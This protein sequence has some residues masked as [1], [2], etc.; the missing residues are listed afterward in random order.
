MKPRSPVLEAL[1]RRYERSQAGRT[2]EASRDVLALVAGVLGTL[3]AAADRFK[4]A[5][6]EA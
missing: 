3:A 2:G 4:I 5:T 6:N 1:A